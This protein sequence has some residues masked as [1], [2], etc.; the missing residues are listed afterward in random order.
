MQHR[1]DLSSGALNRS[2]RLLIQ[3]IEGDTPPIVAIVWPTKPTMCTP[4]SY[5]QVAAAAMRLLADASTR[6]AAIRLWKKL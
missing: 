4:D 5:A 3:L 1:T 2:D 6:L